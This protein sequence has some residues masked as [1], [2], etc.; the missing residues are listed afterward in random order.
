MIAIS[1][2]RINP[3]FEER[4]RALLGLTVTHVI[5]VPILALAM[6]MYVQRASMGLG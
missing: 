2:L 6:A 3:Y 1:V 4:P 5:L